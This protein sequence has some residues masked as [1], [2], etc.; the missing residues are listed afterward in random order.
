MFAL[1]AAASAEMTY[2]VIRLL[3]VALSCIPRRTHKKQRRNFWRKFL[4]KTNNHTWERCRATCVLSDL[5]SNPTPSVALIAAPHE[6]ACLNCSY[7]HT[8]STATSGAVCYACWCPI[9]REHVK[10]FFA[11]KPFNC[12]LLYQH[13]FNNLHSSV[14]MRSFSA[15]INRFQVCFSG[16]INKK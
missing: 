5:A 4:M 9:T 8:R 10:L 12:L 11:K 3:H 7:V 1:H 15:L 14:W 16:L 2:A 6:I 13:C